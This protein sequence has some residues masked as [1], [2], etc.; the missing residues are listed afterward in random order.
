MVDDVARVDL[1]RWNLDWRREK[2]VES[3]RRE[4]RKHLL[5]TEASG[6]NSRAALSRKQKANKMKENKK[7]DKGRG[8][9]RRK[10]GR[11][12][13]DGS[14]ITGGKSAVGVVDRRG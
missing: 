6:V 14:Q 8:K 11:T 10:W 2:L 3:A 9:K 13:A 7:K 4:E 12:R 5:E 1:P